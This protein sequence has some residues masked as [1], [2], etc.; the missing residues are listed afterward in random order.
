MRSSCLTTAPK[1][2][3]Q[4]PEVP[5]LVKYDGIH[6]LSRHTSRG[7]AFGR[8]RVYLLYTTQACGIESTSKKGNN[9]IC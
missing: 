6:I 8:G 4:V 5:S 9:N 1:T 7:E 2:D 3:I